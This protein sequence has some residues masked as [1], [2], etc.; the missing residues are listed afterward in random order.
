MIRYVKFFGGLLLA[1]T[2]CGAARTEAQTATDAAPLQP[3]AIPPPVPPP[4]PPRQPAEPIEAVKA[5]P[6]AAAEIAFWNSVKDTRNPAEI[7]AY[8]DKYPTGT[9]AG[10]ATIRHGELSKAAAVA[11]P[12]PAASKPTAAAVAAPA[13][14]A[15]ATPPSPPAG[16]ASVLVDTATIREVQ[17]K[18]F[19][20][21]YQVRTFSGQMNDDT[22]RAIREWQQKIGQPA[23][24][25]ITQQQLTTLR[26][27]R[28]A[29]TWGAL[30]YAARG[31]S[32][33]VWARGSRADAERDAL[34]E[35]KK[36]GV[37]DCK[38]VTAADKGCG[39]LGFYTGRVGSSQHY[40]A[41]AVVRPSLG[42]ATDSALGECRTQAKVTSACGI[43]VTF[44]AD[45]SHKK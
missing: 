28:V 17:T 30:A 27:G 19:N 10:L 39:A 24:G 36:Y 5:A 16:T 42:Q 18:L 21:N 31:A 20:L 15:S 41:Y 33:A 13:P 44:C 11:A 38:V 43:R 35:C 4:V 1:G 9:F 22:R 6:D 12:K 32:S 25:D 23:T 8:L 2:A 3:A 34:A 40:G 29:T 37:T 7:K 45:G 26:Q 14:V